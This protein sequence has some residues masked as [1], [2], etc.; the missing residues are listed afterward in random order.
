METYI[1]KSK[2][3]AGQPCRF[4]CVVKAEFEPR[5]CLYNAVSEQW[6]VLQQ[7]D[8]IK[9]VCEHV[10]VEVEADQMGNT[11]YCSKCGEWNF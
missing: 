7:A 3:M 10:K 6:E 8:V 11:H 2:I 9:S 4:N 5:G 1:C